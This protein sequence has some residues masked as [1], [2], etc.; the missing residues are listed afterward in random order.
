MS[1]SNNHTTK[2]PVLLLTTTT[3]LLLLLSIFSSQVTSS[4]SSSSSSNSNDLVTCHSV[5]KLRHKQQ[6]C[7]LHS[8]QVTYGTGS[9]QQSVTCFPGSGDSNSYW[10]VKSP[11]GTLPE[12]ECKPGT[13]VTHKMKITLEHVNTHARL[14]SHLH[15][16]PLSQ[17]Q[18]VSAY[19]NGDSGD[20]WIVEL[21][22][23]A[24]W[25]R[26][27]AIRLQHVDTGKFLHS[28]H[29]KFGRPIPDQHE[30][31]GFADKNSN[32]NLWIAEEGIYYP[33]SQ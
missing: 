17:Q 33:S 26:G 22:S 23:G 2:R 31:T 24:E 29:H 15:R 8:H 5:I 12:N 30:V 4:S 6:S 13:P 32:E 7:S 19:P 3:L 11:H 10:I 27:K 28:H 20:N 21:T 1:P 14:H 18:E 25:V 16:S 9:G